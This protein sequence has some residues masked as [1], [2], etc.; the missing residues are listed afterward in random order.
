MNSLYKDSRSRNFHSE[1]ARM[2]CVRCVIQVVAIEAAAPTKEP[3]AAANAVTTVEFIVAPAFIHGHYRK[4]GKL[5]K[6]H[7]LRGIT[8]DPPDVARG[9]YLGE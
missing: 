8:L 6:S 7:E 2:V 1:L 3:S 5:P 9:A 4:G